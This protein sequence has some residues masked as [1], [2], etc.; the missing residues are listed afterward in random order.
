[1]SPRK[2]SLWLVPLLVLAILA[3]STP[4]DAGSITHNQ[5]PNFEQ[6]IRDLLKKPPGVITGL[7]DENFPYQ[8]APV[9]NP[10]QNPSLEIAQQDIPDQPVGWHTS[11]WGENTAVFNY[12]NEGHIGSRSVSVVVSDYVDG[13]AKW[14]FTPVELTPGAD[15][16]FSNYYRSDVESKVVLAVHTG[17]DTIEY[18]GLPN[19][20]AS[21]GWREY[22][23][24]FTMPNHGVSITAYHLIA[25]D[26]YLI[27]D[28]Y[29]IQP[30]SPEGF[31]RGI[32]TITFDDGWEENTETALPIMQGFGYKS[33]Q[34]YATTF[35]EN[36][37]VPGPKGLIQLFIDA[38]HEIGS[39]SVTHADLTTLTPGELTDE[40]VESKRFLEDLLHVPAKYFAAPY[41]AYNQDVIEAIM[42]HY[43]VHRTVDI[44]YNSRDNFDVAGLKVQNI[45]SNTT[46]EEVAFWVQKAK[47][48]RTWLILVYHRVANNPGFYD[49]TPELFEG[50]LQRI[51]DAEIPVL[52]I[53][54]ALLEIAAQGIGIM[55]T[56]TIKPIEG[57]ST[58]YPAPGA[59]NYYQDTD[60]TLTAAPA[61]G[62]Q[63]EKWV[64]DGTEHT[65]ATITVTMDADKTAAVYFTQAGDPIEWNPWTPQF[66]VPKN[67][68]WTIEFNKTLDIST[69]QER[70]IYVTDKFGQLISMFY[71]QR[72][73]DID[74]K[75]Y[76]M[77]VR[78][79]TPGETYTL[80]TKD[81]NAKDGTVLSKNVKMEFTINQ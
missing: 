28:D 65:E 8:D 48:D 81:L 26:G 41:G 55:R 18:I 56:L 76:V 9:P 11:S 75:I 50:H 31:D 37:Y 59:Y 36:P 53:S 52:T 16:Q 79:Y 66:N 49:T 67:K 63:F 58:T 42:E 32:L 40:L 4:I 25:Q 78:D 80:W 77:P 38:G 62:W 24:T 43:Q 27:T 71:Y 21:A 60:V 54:E 64:I 23:A 2:V 35:I 14:F 74:R 68:T 47:Q 70:N 57:E 69:I 5:D 39:H 61:K 13:D 33:N 73:Q 10:I 34:F 3:I 72:Y 51:K 29:L 7:G 30:Y 12:L 6:Q 17:S 45:L 46:P 44:G 22:R 15:Y 19:A 20:P 1:M